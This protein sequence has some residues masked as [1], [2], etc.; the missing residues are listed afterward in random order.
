MKKIVISLKNATERQ[1]HIINEFSKQ[2]IEFEFFN[3]ITPD[4]IEETCQKLE[5]N[6]TENQRLSNGEKGCFLSHL[7]LWQKMIDE[8]IG[9]LA[10]FEDDVFLGQN[11]HIFLNDEQWL[12]NIDFNIIK[13]E[14]WKELVHLGK[15]NI[16]VFDRQLKSLKSTHV[17]TAGY[18]ITKET[19]TYLVDYVKQIPI[20]R[21]FAVDHLI[22]GE[23]LPQLNTYQLVPALAIQADCQNSQCL[24]SQIEHQRSSHTFVYQPNEDLFTEIG[25]FV[26][27]LKRSFGKRTYYQRVDFS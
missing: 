5:L 3:A 27:R 6:L 12:K 9:Y 14:T 26:K 18:V 25:K 17:G 15:S 16:D 19:S 7:S 24:P 4:L 1:E 23:L 21:L 13:L 8:N 2:G 11:A 22:F 10:I 20:H